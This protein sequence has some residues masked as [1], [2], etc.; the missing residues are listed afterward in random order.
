MDYIHRKKLSLFLRWCLEIVYMY[1]VTSHVSFFYPEQFIA[2]CVWAGS[3]CF[4]KLWQGLTCGD[5]KSF[6]AYR[7]AT[8][9]VTSHF[10]LSARRGHGGEQQQEWA[11]PAQ[12][13]QQCVLERIQ[14]NMAI[15]LRLPCKAKRSRSIPHLVAILSWMNFTI[16]LETVWKIEKFVWFANWGS[17][18]ICKTRPWCTYV[19]KGNS[20]EGI[21]IHW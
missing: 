9:Q 1:I 3:D 17:F 20:L 10:S 19:Y 15:K 16:M 6:H 5:R 4:T 18:R 13:S 2:C 14:H 7:R 12:Q 8:A 11:T 21:P